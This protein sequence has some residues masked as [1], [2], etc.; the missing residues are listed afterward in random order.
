VLA[1]SIHDGLDEFVEFMLLVEVRPD[2][3]SVTWIITTGESLFASVI[4]KWN[5]SGSE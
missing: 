5:T 1:S 4:H 2:W 3:F